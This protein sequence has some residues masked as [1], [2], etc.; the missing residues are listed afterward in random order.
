MIMLIDTSSSMMQM[1]LILIYIQ[2]NILL[3][4]VELDLYIVHT[5]LSHSSSYYITIMILHNVTI[6]YYSLCD[7]LRHLNNICKLQ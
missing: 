6:S 4:Q 2:Y 1:V 5:Y 3:A 7:A